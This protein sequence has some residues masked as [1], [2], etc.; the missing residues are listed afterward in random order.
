MTTLVLGDGWLGKRLKAIRYHLINLPG[1]VLSHGRRL[2]LR[3]AHGHPSLSI[4]LAARQRI[5]A[6]ARGS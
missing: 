3:L 4:L 6:L 2:V 5:A 1:R